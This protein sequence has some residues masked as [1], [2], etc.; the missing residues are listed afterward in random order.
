M[1]REELL[2]KNVF[3]IHDFLSAEECGH[4][5]AES[6]A[7]GY[8]DAPVTTVFG[9]VVRPDV[10]N[11]NRVIIDDPELATT[12]FERARPFLPQQLGEWRLAGLN[13]RF[14]FY[15][16]DPGQVFKRHQDGSYFRSVLEQSFLTFMVY[17]NAGYVGGSTEFFHPGGRITASTVPQAGM[18][19]V[20]DHQQIHE[21]SIVESGR[22]YV[23]RTDV[24][25][26][27]DR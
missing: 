26:R 15:R 1:T 18:A 11:N 7:Q 27:R 9:P 25:Y 8:E 4:F 14:R 22:K 21:G 23:L 13:E 5:I 6:E 19:L 12:W 10:R 20:F 16:Y 3:V 2:G 17:L 24:M